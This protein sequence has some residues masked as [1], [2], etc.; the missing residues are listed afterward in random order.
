MTVKK[1]FAFAAMVLGLAPAIA[2]AADLGPYR[3]APQA[4]PAPPPSYG[5]PERYNWSGLYLGLSGGYAWG[6]SSVDSEID[7]SADLQ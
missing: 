7:D 6:E 1:C 4:P 2:E 5:E 3:P